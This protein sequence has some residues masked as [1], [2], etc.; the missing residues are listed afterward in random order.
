MASIHVQLSPSFVVPF[1][2]VRRR[3]RYH[4]DR[5]YRQPG[6]S[7]SRWNVL[8]AGEDNWRR[9]LRAYDSHGAGERIAG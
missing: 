8:R 3:P 5:S 2:A 4:H 9:Q 6:W 1:A 7:W